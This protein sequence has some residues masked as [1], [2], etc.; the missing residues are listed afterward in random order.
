[1]S[2][3]T[4]KLY[5]NASQYF[6]DLV[7]DI[8]KAKSCIDFEVY[9]FELDNIGKEVLDALQKASLRGVKVRLLLDGFGTPNWNTISK[10]HASENFSI[11][12]YHPLPWPFGKNILSELHPKKLIWRF[13]Q[14]N[15]RNHKKLVILDRQ[16]TYSGS[17]NVTSD[18]LKWFDIGTRLIGGPIELLESSFNH[19]WES[20][21]SRIQARLNLSKNIEN[22]CESTDVYLNSTAKLRRNR[23]SRLLNKILN[24]TTEIRVVSAYFVPPLRLL[25]ALSEARSR[26]IKISLILPNQSD[27]PIVTW[28]GRHLYSTLLDQGVLIYEYHPKILHAKTWFFENEVLVGSSNLNNRSWK[29]DLEVDL[30]LR[31]EESISEMSLIWNEMIGSC[32]PVT[33]MVISRWSIW[34]Y[35]GA[36]L[37]SIFRYWA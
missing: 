30:A 26:N 5:S 10:A 17:L 1:M 3:Q 18:H 8:S 23:N 32:I 31:S 16:I 22:I 13:A 2:W 15:R 11:R 14:M 34:K 27:V 20:S 29:H 4:E 37:L 19:S 12:P 24:T 33:D 28:F 6:T 9:I 25:S 21:D 7:S 35:W 36:K